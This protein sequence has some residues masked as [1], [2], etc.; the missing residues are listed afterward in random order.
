MN[1]IHQPVYPLKRRVKELKG[2]I[3]DL[4][5]IENKNS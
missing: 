3:A 5:L 2:F 4:V 1:W